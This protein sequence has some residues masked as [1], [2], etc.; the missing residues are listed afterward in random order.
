MKITP[1]RFAKLRVHDRI[2]HSSDWNIGFELISFGSWGDRT[3]WTARTFYEMPLRKAGD[4]FPLPF[5]VFLTVEIEADEMMESWRL[6]G[7][8][9]QREHLH[10]WQCDNDRMLTLR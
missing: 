9:K 3:V 1:E 5:E 7:K 4:F 6:A 8:G 2:F 10:E